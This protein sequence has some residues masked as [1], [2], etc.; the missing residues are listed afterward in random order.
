[1]AAS[2]WRNRTVCARSRAARGPPPGGRRRRRRHRR[3]R[4][5]RTRARPPPATPSSSV[6][7]HWPRSCSFDSTDL[8]YLPR[9]AHA[10][11]GGIAR[12]ILRAFFFR[13]APRAGGPLAPTFGV[14]V[15]AS[16]LV[17]LLCFSGCHCPARVAVRSLRP[18]VGQ[19]GLARARL[20][21]TS[22]LR[23]A[24]PFSASPPPPPGRCRWQGGGGHS[25]VCF[26]QMLRLYPSTL[27][28]PPPPPPPPPPTWRGCPVGILPLLRRRRFGVPR[29]CRTCCQ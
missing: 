1:V 16:C 3:R 18:V 22:L 10:A 12:G 4:R 8:V 17:A 24:T 20:R 7:P 14:R 5:G 13:R 11:A 29:L 6:L 23:P 26:G 28:P 19:R 21:P 9:S 25:R 2:W 15:C 27:L